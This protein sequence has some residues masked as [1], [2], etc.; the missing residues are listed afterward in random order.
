MPIDAR[1]IDR[2]EGILRLAETVMD[3]AEVD[4]QMRPHLRSIQDRLADRFVDERS[5][6][7]RARLIP[8]GRDRERFGVF[9]GLTT[10]VSALHLNAVR[11]LQMTDFPS[12]A[13]LQRATENMNRAL[14]GELGP[15]YFGDMMLEAETAALRRPSF[16]QRLAEEAEIIGSMQAEFEALAERAESLFLGKQESPAS[17]ELNGAPIP[18][19][20][21]LI[22]IAL[23]LVWCILKRCWRV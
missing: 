21:L 20:L 13:D 6:R 3:M 8:R 19:W 15:E 17:C 11:E 23:A 18:C 7:M 22:L 5:I 2:E 14:Q 16:A 1:P 10:L 4:E 9:G 12:R